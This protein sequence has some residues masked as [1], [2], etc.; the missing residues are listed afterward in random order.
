M[1]KKIIL[2][3]VAFALF[4]AATSGC[5]TAGTATSWPGLTV[6]DDLSYVAFGN[7]VYAVKNDNGNL[8]WR[9]PQ[10]SENS[11]S[12]FAAP[13]VEENTLVTGNYHNVLYGVNANTG[14]QKWV[15]NGAKDRFIGSPLLKNGITYAPN[16]DGNLYALD[17]NGQLLWKFKSH[18]A[19][20]SKPVTDGSNLYFGSMDHFVY[21]LKL[22]YTQDEIVADEN[23][24][25]IAIQ[26]PLWSVDLGS[27]IFANP[28]LSPQGVLYFATLEGKVFAISSENGDILWTFP[29]EGQINGIWAA[30]VLVDELLYVSD[31]GDEGGSIYGLSA[32][33]GNAQ[34]AAPYNAGAPIIGGGMA[35]PDGAG[36]VTTNGIFIKLNT[37][38]T[39]SWT[40]QFSETTYTAPQAQNGY[41]ILAAVGKEYLLAKFDQNGQYWLFNPPS[42]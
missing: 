33:T 25:R 19:N 22:N 18:K 42:D 17:S 8:A 1:K 40:K 4:A 39:A 36:F 29:Q 34:W 7:Y 6:T 27:A 35:F 13:A 5:T 3:A 32:T 12:F 14:M 31:A 2:L 26:Q 10:T 23:G 41:I 9:F 16:A 11:L 20:W 15:F 24:L 21:A 28:I 37:S 38:G 30:P